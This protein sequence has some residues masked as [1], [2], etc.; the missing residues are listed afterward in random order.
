M[1]AHN[2]KQVSLGNLVQKR[3][4]LCLTYV[5]NHPTD[6]PLDYESLQL[7][8]SQYYIGKPGEDPPRYQAPTLPNISHH[9]SRYHTDVFRNF[10]CFLL[11]FSTS[12]DIIAEKNRDYFARITYMRR[13]VQ[14]CFNKSNACLVFPSYLVAFIHTR[15]S[16]Q[17]TE[18]QIDVTSLADKIWLQLKPKESGRYPTPTFVLAS[19]DFNYRPESTTGCSICWFCPANKRWSAFHCGENDCSSVMIDVYL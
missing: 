3:L 14:R 6:V 18:A 13:L 15:S 11:M 7:P 9:R 17:N 10:R 2:S 8:I 19:N 1:F 16:D 4:G 5:M 12:L